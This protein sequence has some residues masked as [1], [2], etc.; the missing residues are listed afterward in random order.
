MNGS[1]VLWEL[2]AFFVYFVYTSYFEWVLHRYIFHTPKYIYS[3]F[4]KHTLVHHQ[5]YKGDE[6]YHTDEDHPDHVPMNWWALPMMIL[7]HLPLFVG[8]QLLTGIPSAWGGIIALSVY[9]A[10]YESLHWA[11]H[12]PRA[13]TFL[14]RFRVYCFLDAHHHVHHKYM[15]SNLNVIFPL[16]DLMFGTL[17]DADG[18]KVNLRILWARR[19]SRRAAPV[20]AVPSLPKVAQPVS[21]AT[22]RQSG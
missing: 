13:A 20:P 10:L 2:G 19:S 17:R 5:V 3:M 14:E 7:I 16:P 11:M 18:V 21:K 15:L 4:R 12:V 1:T 9:Y 8:M 6:T 22:M